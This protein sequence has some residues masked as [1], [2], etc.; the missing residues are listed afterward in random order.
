MNNQTQ[1]KNALKI[2]HLFTISKDPKLLEELLADDVVFYSPV[3]HT[4]QEGKRMCTGY[5]MAALM[6]LGDDKSDFKYENE[7]VNDTNAILEFT[8]IIDGI[9]INGVDMIHINEEGKVDR[10]K[11]MIRPLKAINL[12]H[13]KMGEILKKMQA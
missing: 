6:V 8:A 1:M 13:Q 4:P 2:W 10:F 9:A 3:V 12:I 11:V 5:L 7:V